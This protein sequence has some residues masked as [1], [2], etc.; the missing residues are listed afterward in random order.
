MDP[1]PAE[2]QEWIDSLEALARDEGAERAR[3]VMRELQRRAS[4]ARPGVPDVRQTDYIN[5]IH[6]EDEP[7]YPGDIPTEKRFAKMVRWNAA[8]MVHRAQRPGV[9]VGGH[10]STFASSAT[11]TKWLTTTSSAARSTRRRR[12][13]VLP[14]HAAPGIYAR[15]FVLGRFGSE[16][17]DGFRQELSA[18]RRRPA[19]VPAPAADARLLAVPDRLDGPRTAARDLSGALQPLSGRPRHQGTR[20]TSTWAFVGDGETDEPETLG[21]I[22]TAAREEFDNLT[23]VINCNLQRLDGPVH[24]NGKIIQEP[25][26]ALP[27]RRLERHQGDLGQSWDQLLAMDSEGA[28]VNLMNNTLD[29]D[30]QT[31]KAED[32]GFIREYFFN[33]DPRTA[34]MV[35]DWTDD[36]I[37]GCTAAATTTPGCTR[38]TPP[39]WRTRQSHRGAGQDR[40]GATRSART[41]RGATPP[42][43]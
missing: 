12:P 23:F 35:A 25:G 1:D 8:M 7:D 38:P 6:P 30:Y 13:G 42:T 40:Q 5:T 31:M 24:G 15:S 33:R 19:V 28:L 9:G 27:G 29:G 17:L 36:E 26:S 39:H 32:G 41:S 22:M 11:S 4:E 21:K 14:G 20:P 3:F 2:S 37:W 16:R 34:A 43:R 18:R 10:I